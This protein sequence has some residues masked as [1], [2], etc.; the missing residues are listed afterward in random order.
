MDFIKSFSSKLKLLLMDAIIMG[1]TP[2]LAIMIRFEGRIPD[3]EFA[4]FHDSLPWMVS[5]SLIIF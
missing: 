1:I 3:K 5:L 2:I 4:A